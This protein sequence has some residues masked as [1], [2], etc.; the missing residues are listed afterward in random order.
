MLVRH[1]MALI[2]HNRSASR[3]HAVREAGEQLFVERLPFLLENP[4][5]LISRARESLLDSALQYAP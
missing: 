1:L 2:R 4:L 3:G 5:N